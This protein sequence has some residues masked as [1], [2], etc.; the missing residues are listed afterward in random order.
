M[1]L[2]LGAVLTQAH[3]QENKPLLDSNQFSIGVGISDNEIG[4]PDEDDTGFQFFAA[5]YLN[6]I[7]LME[8][9]NSSVEFGFMDFGFDNDDTGIWASYV[10]DGTI[11]GR[12]GW[13][14]QAGLD[15]GDDSGL[16]FGAG[17]QFM[18]NDKSDL[19]FEYVM[20]DE[21]DSLQINF[22]YHL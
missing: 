2:T 17:L 13:L 19:R 20:R 16:L 14:A 9:V 1:V 18:L 10:V 11:S 8:G 4:S 3:A 21:V 12:L 5:Y 6:Q 15:I 22:L 7:N